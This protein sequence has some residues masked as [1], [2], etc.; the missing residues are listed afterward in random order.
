LRSH[1]STRGST[2]DSIPSLFWKRVREV[3]ERVA[4]RQKKY[5]IWEDISWGEYGSVAKEVACGL[6]S[7]GLEKGD[8]VSVIGENSPEWLYSDMGIMAAGGITVGIYTTNSAEEVKYILDHSQSKFYIVEN[9]EQL[10]KAL[11]VRHE[12]PFLKK[13]VVVDMEGLRT[14]KDPM[15]M[16]FEQL[17]DLGRERDRKEPSLFENRLNELDPDEVALLIYTSGTTGPPK[18]AMLSHRNILWTVEKVAE[19]LK[20]YETDEVVSFLPLSH[21][22]ER[23]F[24]VFLPLQYKYTTNFIENTD[25]VAQNIVEVSPTVLFAV[26]RIWEKYF[27]TIFIKMQEAALFKKV[28]FG[29]AMKMGKRYSEVKLTGDRVP[30]LLRLGFALV[31][32][33]VF[34]KLKKRLGLERVRVAV[35]GAAPIS[36]DVLKFYHSIGI[37]LREVYGQTEGCGPTC[38]H[39]GEEIKAGTV[40][41]P[42]PEVEVKLAQDGEILVKG[43]NV[44]LGYF[45]NEQATT[46]TLVD[47]WLRSGDVGEFDRNGFLLITDRKKDL[48]ITSGGKNVAPQNI[49]NQL[50]FSPYIND[51][52]V[53]GDRRKYLAALIVIDEDNVVKY[54]TD[55][56]IQYTTYASLTRTDEVTKLIQQQ[57]D[58]VNKSLARVEQIKKFRI[59]PKKLMEEDGEVTPTMKVKRNYINE[60]FADLIESMY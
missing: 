36:P 37:P 24:S 21:I 53:I 55:N 34:R 2:D 48:I 19:V 51:A 32:F 1:D 60:T 56:K 9:E 12:L 45:R 58:S 8:C 59:L 14:F 33:L 44:F 16:S 27:S 11:L 5:G 25:T 39:R 38:I 30:M 52:V 49:E 10:D 54:A 28:T 42:L 23:M 35:S 20:V 15:V 40:G 13:I 7:L 6:I 22:A 29:M 41:P 4:L 57:V 3:D 31:H 43:G 17:R 46:A 50:K 18:G 26:P 47:G